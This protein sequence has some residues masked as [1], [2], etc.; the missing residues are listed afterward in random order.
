LFMQVPIT[1]AILNRV[2]HAFQPVAFG[3]PFE[4]VLPFLRHALSDGLVSL[5][6]TAP[7]VIRDQL[8]ET[9][10]MLCEPDPCRRGHP[11]EHP[12]TI[13]FKFTIR[14]FLSSFDSMRQRVQL[15]L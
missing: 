9:I 2:P 12:P 14:R 11:A 10:R 6:D 8:T 1:P 5:A 15:S 4:D 13:G 7:P 3:G